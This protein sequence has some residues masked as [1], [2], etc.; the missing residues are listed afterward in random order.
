VTFTSVFRHY[1][2]KVRRSITGPFCRDDSVPGHS[3]RPQAGSF[4]PALETL[5]DRT[6]PSGNTVVTDATGTQFF[7]DAS[8]HYVFEIA[9]GGG[10]TTTGPTSGTPPAWSGTAR[11]TS[12]P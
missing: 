10:G 8:T 12:S 1:L 7:L 11:G 3:T 5:E 6:V 9:P 2:D 4:R